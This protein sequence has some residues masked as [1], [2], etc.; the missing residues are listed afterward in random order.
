MDLGER[1]HCATCV[2]VPSQIEGDGEG[3]LEQLHCLLGVAEQEVQAAEVVRE[4]ADVDAVGELRIGRACALGVVARQHPVTLAV[5]YERRLEVG[6]A[7]RAEVLDA[8]RQL[9]RPLDVV[10]GGF[11][12]PLAL[13]AARPPRKDVGLERVAR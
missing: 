10:A 6:G 7:D 8:L 4:L 2:G 12:V 1:G 5:G 11:E 3:L 9:E 13:P